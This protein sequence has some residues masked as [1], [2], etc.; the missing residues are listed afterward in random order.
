MNDRPTYLKNFLILAVCLI[1][2]ALPQISEAQNSALV[3]LKE[4][5]NLQ[6]ES[7]KKN[8]KLSDY[9]KKAKKMPKEKSSRWLADKFDDLQIVPGKT[10]NLAK[11]K[12]DAQKAKLQKY[13]DALKQSEF[14]ELEAMVNEHLD[15]EEDELEN[16]KQQ[17]TQL[18]ELPKPKP[19]RLV[20]DT[21]KNKQAF[22]IISELNNA[23]T[24]TYFENKTL[25]ISYTPDTEL[26]QSSTIASIIINSVN[27]Q[28]VSQEIEL[29][30]KRG[31]NQ[32]VI[33]T[34]LPPGKYFFK[35]KTEK[36][37]IA[38]KFIFL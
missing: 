38:H 17:K 12:L 5:I 35:L 27:F 7:V 4:R 31:V 1:L 37:I 18:K 13:R 14:E 32:W 6:K 15:K 10:K 22:L 20:T 30:L 36:L 29:P 33:A 21:D 19:L 26:L 25:C 8:R 2:C 23:N 3:D 34:K 11:K 24:T 9:V 16:L 28:S